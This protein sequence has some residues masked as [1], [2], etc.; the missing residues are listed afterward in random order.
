MQDSKGFSLIEVLVSMVVVSVIML[1]LAYFYIAL[2]QRNTQ[3][4]L[5]QKA[6]ETMQSV[7]EGFRSEDI[8]DITENAADISGVT[9]SDIVNLNSYCNPDDSTAIPKNSRHSGSF[10]F[11]SGSVSETGAIPYR[12][13]YVVFTEESE[14]L[15]LEDT[16]TVVATICWKSRDKISYLTRKSVVLKEGML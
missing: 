4:L 10:V 15:G 6:E 7:F 12:V 9:I 16:I 3:A 1:S 2:K 11:R 14:N 13:V 8:G 5:R